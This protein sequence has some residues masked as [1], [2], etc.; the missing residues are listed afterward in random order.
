MNEQVQRAG[1]NNKS[2]DKSLENISEYKPVY[3]P[4]KRIFFSLT[5]IRQLN[6]SMSVHIY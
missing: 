2:A 5:K 1:L 6:I 4:L 3:L